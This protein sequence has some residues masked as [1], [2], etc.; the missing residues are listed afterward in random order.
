[1]KKIRIIN[2]V[3]ARPNFVKIAPIMEEMRRYRD[4]IVPILVHTGQHFDREMSGLFFKDLRI[5]E[6]DFYLGVGAGSHAGQT[7]KIMQRFEKVLLKIKPALV[8]VVGDVNSTLACALC[9]V[10]LH[11]PVAHVEAGL[12]SFDKAMPEEINRV[13]TDAVSDYLF[14]TEKSAGVNLL[15]EN[16]LKD[17]IYFVGNV[18]I[19]TLLS[20][21][22]K[23][24]G[25]DVLRRLGLEKRGYAVLTLHRPSNVDEKRIF[26]D[27]L[28][29]LSEIQ[30]KIMVT[31]PVHPRTKKM[32][33]DFKLNKRISKMANLRMVSPLG[34]LDFLKLMADSKFVLTDSGGIQEETT[35]LKIP[36]LT[37]RETTERPVTLEKGTNTIVGQDRAA[38]VRESF[39]IMQN[40]RYRNNK[41]PGLWDGNAARRMV[42]ILI[43][44]IGKGNGT[45]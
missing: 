5:P 31:W 41:M 44:E 13:L 14:T 36:C 4:R 40:N 11:I 37:L 20:H 10:K 30:K 38:I 43:K 2:V 28:D 35:I 23:A 27:I 12:R 25:S 18:M 6:P 9:S 16:H 34:Y 29:G 24:D 39:K 26:I 45:H 19:D 17:R 42:R 15:N 1:M 3:G 8:L 21:K 32:I 7:A 33:Y 22:K